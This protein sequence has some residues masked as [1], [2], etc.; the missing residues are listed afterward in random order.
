MPTQLDYTYYMGYAETPH[1]RAQELSKAMKR[2]RQELGLTQQRAADLSY[3]GKGTPMSSGG[4]GRI[5]T[6]G[7]AKNVMTRTLE[8]IDAAL[9][10]DDGMWPAGTALRILNGGAVQAVPTVPTVGLEDLL[11]LVRATARLSKSLSAELSKLPPETVEALTEVNDLTT[12]ILLEL[13][14][15]LSTSES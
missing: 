5:E 7:A 8:K 4:W 3:T 6:V 10:G 9:A 12:D 1:P 13:T 2:R 11:G 15:P 14:D